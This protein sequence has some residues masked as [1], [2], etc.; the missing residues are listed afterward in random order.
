MR[1]V[2]FDQAT[3]VSGWSFWTDGTYVDSGIIDK[4]KIK[5]S[6]ERAAA[7]G[8]AICEKLEELHPD[9]VVIEN[10]QAQAGVSTVILLARLQGIVIGWC[11]AH[12]IRVEVIEPSKWRKC[13]GY[14]QGPG[15][16]R[17]DLKWQSISYVQE[18]LGFDD[19]SEDR[20]EACCLGIAAHKLLNF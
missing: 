8:N 20:C 17:E 4:H 3:K 9:C 12:K 13:L 7:M 18:H 10:V 5:D 16:K 15:V 19:F 14:K 6:N 11:Y 1:V 2:S